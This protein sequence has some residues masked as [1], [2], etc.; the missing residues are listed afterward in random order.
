[1]NTVIITYAA[2][3]VPAALYKAL[4]KRTRALRHVSRGHQHGEWLAIDRMAYT[5]RMRAWNPVLKAALCIFTLLLCII[6]DSPHVSAAVLFAMAFL[7]VEIGGLSLCE[8][9]ATLRIPMVFVL[10]SAA[11]VAV[12]Y[13]THPLGE[14][15][16]GLGTGFLYTSRALLIKSAILTLKVL[17]CISTLDMLILTT[18][19]SEILRVLKK[20]RIPRIL[21]DLMHMI[22]RFIFILLDVAAKMRKAAESRLGYRDMRTSWY[23]FGSIASNLLVLSLKR[24]NAYYDAM[25][26]R[27]YSGELAFIEDEKPVRI[28][29]V[30]V[31]GLFLLYL[32]L[33]RYFAQ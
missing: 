13:S 4:H 19:L 25:E 15:R 3:L 12:E 7:V 21:I 10:L 18:P 22:Y 16:L 17:A 26:A 31:V 14:F 33:V 9:L 1:M 2:L 6:L 27:C 20:A 5:S 28:G 30:A 29:Q 23:T 24:A 8:Y 11:A 32:P